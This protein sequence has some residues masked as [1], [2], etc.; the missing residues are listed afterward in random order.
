MLKKITLIIVLIS[1][2]LSVV[3]LVNWF[4]TNPEEFIEEEIEGESTEE[5]LSEIDATLLGEDNEIEI[6]EMI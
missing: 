1:M 6:G 5:I 3:L 2:I 4:N